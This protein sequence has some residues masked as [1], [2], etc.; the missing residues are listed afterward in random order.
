MIEGETIREIR[1]V[2]T[3]HNQPARAEIR[4]G[5]EMTWKG[6]TIHNIQLT[7][8]KTAII[9]QL[10]DPQDGP[11]GIVIEATGGCCSRSW[12]EH[13]D[14]AGLEG[15]SLN[16]IT[17][18]EDPTKVDENEETCE[19]LKFYKGSLVTESGSHDF[20]LRN[21]SN[22]Y[23]SGGIEVSEYGEK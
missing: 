4:E 21:E 11:S 6:K 20:E 13:V 9:V 8:D 22:G 15:Q 16:D 23:Y 14:F 12:F 7:P 5:S 19:C 1:T 2:S 10:N 18:T 17:F 3:Y